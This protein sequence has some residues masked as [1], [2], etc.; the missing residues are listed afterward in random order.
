MNTRRLINRL[1]LGILLA[2]LCTPALSMPYDGVW[3]RVDTQTSTTEVWQGQER[4][5]VLERVAFG[6]GGISDLHIKGDHTTPRGRFRITRVNKESRF[7]LFLGINYP[8]QQHLDTAHHQGL[9][10]TQEY[11]ASRDHGRIYGEFPQSGTLGGYIGF[12]GIGRGNPQVHDDFHWTQGCIAMTNEQIE[13][14]YAHVEIGTPVV[15]E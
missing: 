8:T 7:H 11:L 6:R 2:V 15:I 5:L 3:V 10:D 4:Q 14:L 9:V 12:H 1:G 13:T